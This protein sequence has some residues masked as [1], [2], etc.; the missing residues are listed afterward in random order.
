[1]PKR[2]RFRERDKL[3][4]YIDPDYRGKNGRPKLAAYQLTD[5]EDSLSVNSLEIESVRQVAATYATKFENGHRPVAIASP[6]ISQFNAAAG[7]VRVNISY[8]SIIGCW[9]FHDSGKYSEAYRF[10]DKKTNKSHCGVE[11]ARIFDEYQEFLFAG[12]MAKACKYRLV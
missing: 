3:A 6:Q 8:D 4:R 5:N 1:M 9:I 7:A 2:P 10:D 11:F 12:R